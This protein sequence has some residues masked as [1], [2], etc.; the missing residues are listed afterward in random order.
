MCPLVYFQ[1]QAGT[2]FQAE[3][4]SQDISGHMSASLPCSRMRYRLPDD[5]TSF[6]SRHFGKSFVGR[7]APA[8]T[9]PEEDKN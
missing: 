5:Y 2:A 8:P 6:P 7:N 1:I 4:L 3:V 9:V